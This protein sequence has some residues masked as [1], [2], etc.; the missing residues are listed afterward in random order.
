MTLNHPSHFW[1]L[2][3]ILGTGLVGLGQITWADAEGIE[4][5]AQKRSERLVTTPVAADV[6]LAGE[7]DAWTVRDVSDVAA[8]SA[9][10]IL[11]QGLAP[12]D[13]RLSIRGLGAYIGH[14]TVAQLVDG[15]N[16]SSEALSFV[17]S[18]TVAAYHFL[19]IERVEV[20]KGP[21]TVFYGPSAFAGAVQYATKNPSRTFQG[22]VR[23][24][25]GGDGHRDLQGTVSGPVLE[26]Q[27]Y[28]RLT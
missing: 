5:T 12:P 7:I 6:I 10:L 20:I 24:E 22:S 2:V 19:D 28:L 21:Q 27:F 17:G 4:V 18:S 3:L 11:N 23:V 16:Y 15:I 1:P 26:N 8:F 13:T 9:S 14:P 25:V